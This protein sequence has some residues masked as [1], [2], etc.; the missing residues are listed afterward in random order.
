[1]QRTAP[2]LL[3]ALGFYS[4]AVPHDGPPHAKNPGHNGRVRTARATGLRNASRFDVG[5]TVVNRSGSRTPLAV[6]LNIVR[7]MSARTLLAAISPLALRATML[8]NFPAHAR[9]FRRFLTPPSLR[10]ILA[11]RRDSAGHSARPI[12]FQA[13]STSWRGHRLTSTVTWASEA[14]PSSARLYF[15]GARGASETMETMA[16]SCPGPTRQT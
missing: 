2:H 10:L 16:A 13:A 15:S 5:A 11:K 6:A 9:S 3:V 1:M 14:T 12:P 4:A 7:A 8:M